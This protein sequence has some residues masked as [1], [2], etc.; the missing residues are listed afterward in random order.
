MASGFHGTPPPGEDPTHAPLLGGGGGGDAR[1]RLR[2]LALAGSSSSSSFDAGDGLGSDS[3][4]HTASV[5]TASGGLPIEDEAR[6]PLGT[7][8]S[9]AVYHIICVIAGSG[10]LQLPYALN[11]SGWVGL[12]IV[13]FA[14]MANKYSG[15]LLVK[16]L[17]SQGTWIAVSVVIVSVPFL[18]F[19][20]LKEIAFFSLMY[21]VIAAIGY[22]AYGDATVSPILNNIPPGAMATFSVAVITAHVLAAI[23]VVVTSFS[24]E[25][26]RRLAIEHR[27]WPES[28]VTIARTI[29]RVSIMIGLAGLAMI[30]PFFADFMTLLGAV[31]NTVRR[32]SSRM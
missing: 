16:C 31:A 19:K 28:K 13:V 7:T 24:L 5:T 6:S 22:A 9:E 27:N 25:M 3:A 11:Q 30:I 18:T 26:E 10:V 1:G 17:Y 21:I 14:A 4:S 29:L 23:P 12:L 15:D 2:V 20:T 32:C 8:V